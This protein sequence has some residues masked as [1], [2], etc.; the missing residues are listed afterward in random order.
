MTAAA[1]GA[2]DFLSPQVRLRRQRDVHFG[3]Y[4]KHEPASFESEN[5]RRAEKISPRRAGASAGLA[6][7]GAREFRRLGACAS[8]TFR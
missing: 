8:G 4:I 5:L 1:Q 7:G 6:R 3:G 2:S